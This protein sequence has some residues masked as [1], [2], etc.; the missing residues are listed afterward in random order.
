MYYSYLDTPIGRLM[1]AGDGEGVREIGFPE[2]KMARRA[3][4][5]WVEN[6]AALSAARSQLSAYFA[7][8]RIGFDLPLA[9]QTTPF[10]SVVL[11]ALQ[12]VP[13][14]QTVSYGELASRIGKPKASRA[15]G[16]ANGRNPIPIIIPCHRV[17]AANG[18]LTGF[19]GG[20][21]TKRW[22]LDHERKVLA[23][24]S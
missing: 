16:M 2:G 20:L 13:Y 5:D 15:V 11:T 1:I 17:I 22:L 6:D 14:G 8:E 24:R 21:D 7:G 19:G 12:K 10:Q 18:A 4:A 9:P 3:E 23:A